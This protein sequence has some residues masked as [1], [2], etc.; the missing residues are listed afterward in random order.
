MF[1]LSPVSYS[2]E[3]MDLK[4]STMMLPLFYQ[5]TPKVKRANGL[6]P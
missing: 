3:I 5:V 6:H 1:P 4:D 2:Q